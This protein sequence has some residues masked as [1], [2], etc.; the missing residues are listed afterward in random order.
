MIAVDTNVVVRFLTRDDE[1]QYEKSL[2]LFQEQDILILDTVILE[3]EWVLLSC[4][5]F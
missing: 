5:N 2:K 3:T 4:Y 1:Q